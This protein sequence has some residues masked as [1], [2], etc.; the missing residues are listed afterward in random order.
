MNYANLIRYDAANGPGWRVSLFVSGCDMH[1]TGCFNQDAQ[2]Y[3]FGSV[4]TSDIKQQ[5]EDTIRDPRVTGL[6]LLGGD[7]LSQDIDALSELIDLVYSVRHNGK[8]VWMWTGFQWEDIFTQEY[9]ADS[10]YWKMRTLL[11][12]MVDVLVD[13]EFVE[14]LADPSLEFRGSSNQ[15][16]IDVQKS[17]AAGKVVLWSEV[18]G[19][20]SIEEY[21]SE[22]QHEDNKND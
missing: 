19:Q 3:S 4:Y 10:A 17:L 18:P 15:R 2:D 22:V 21:M 7:P 14:E 20:I 6:S 8:T 9:C 11:V 5:I 13:G 16:I 12:R 1:C